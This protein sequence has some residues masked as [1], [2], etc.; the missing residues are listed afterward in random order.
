M[1]IAIPG[2]SSGLGKLVAHKLIGEGHEVIGLDRRPWPDAPSGVSMHQ[3][4]I[5]KRSAEDVFRTARPE[6]VIHMATVTHLIEHTA[7]RYRINLGGTQAVFRYCCDYGVKHAV[8]VGRHTYYGAAPDSP[9][10]HRED[11]PPMAGHRFPELADLVAADLYAA[12]ALW[13]HPELTTSVLR[14]CYTIGPS[15]HGS[16]GTFLRGTRIPTVLGFDPLFQFI[17][18]DD[19]SNAIL[20]AIT[21]RLRG[22]YNV[23]GPPPMPLSHVIRETG[24]TVLPLPERIFLFMQGKFG[25]P[26]LPRGA[27]DHLKYSV[28]IDGEAFRAATGFSVAHDEFAALQTYRKTFPPAP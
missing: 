24:R 13:R 22:V 14:L 15:G 18:E 3:V 26:S 6:A 12:T 1:I 2:I 27:V 4:D 28:V 5:R 9:L 10:Y 7:E 17:H 21:H 20:L 25:F 16:L 11:E 8:F 23:A 19:V